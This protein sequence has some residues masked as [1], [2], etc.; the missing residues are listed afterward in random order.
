MRKALE[1]QLK[2]YGKEHGDVARSY[3]NLGTLYQ[4]QGRMDQAEEYLRKALGIKLRMYGEEQDNVIL[5]Y[6]NLG[7]LFLSR[8]NWI[9]QRNMAVRHLLSAQR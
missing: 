8:I 1:I 4:D 6:S 5:A 7:S 9:W 3:N 2:L